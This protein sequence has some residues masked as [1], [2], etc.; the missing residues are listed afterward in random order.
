MRKRWFALGALALWAVAVYLLNASFLANPREQGSMLAHRG[1]HQ[2]FNIEGVDNDTCT[3]TRV[4][5]V[6]HTF[7]E[8]TPPSIRRAFELGADMVEIDVHPTTDG[9]FAVFHDWTLECRT[10]GRGETRAHAMGEL[11]ALDV[12]YG[13]TADGG[14]T[15]PLR[16]LG[17]GQMPSL[18]E[19]LAAFPGR[20]FMINFKS[21]DA[22]EGEA[23][24]GY[25]AAFPGADAERLVF[26]GAEPAVR[27]RELRPNWRI[28]TAATLKRCA[29]VYVLTGWFGAVPEACRNT[30][31]FL[32]VNYAPFA[33]DWPDRLLQRMQD[34]GSEVYL[35]GPAPLGQRPRFTGIDDAA[36]L[37]R[38][39]AG[40]RGGVSTDAVEVVGPLVARP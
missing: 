20:R 5:P 18:R 1:V 12:G 7:I 9:D 3:A 11:R 4:Y 19:V 36:A 25:L 14:A 34:A 26:F 29:L 10:N 31:I 21:R 37:A 38:I 33:W 15:F 32:P 13:Y 6:T 35:S 40:W 30:V 22:A 16:G 17:V 27:L 2:R 39:P 24:A 8:N 28:V 23:M